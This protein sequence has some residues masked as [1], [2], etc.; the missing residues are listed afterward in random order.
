MLPLLR[1][2]LLR[3]GLLL[4]A[5]PIPKVSAWPGHDWAQWRQVTTWTRPNLVTRQTGQ[6]NL[7]PV[8]GTGDSRV[9]SP[10]LWDQERARVLA[11]VQ[12]IL[13]APA[14]LTPLPVEVREMETAEAEGYTRRHLLIRS[15]VEDW[16]P[17]YLLI[18]RQP[19]AARAPAMICL[20]QTVA[21]GKDEPCGLKGD[22][23]LA[24]AVELARRGYVCLAPDAIGFGERI[25]SGGQPYDGSL[26]FY[27][28]HPNWS[29][30]GKMVWDVSRLVDYLQTLPNVDARRIGSIGHSHGAYGT[31]F[32]AAL[33][34]RLT[35]A[36]A[37]CGFTTFRRDPNPERWSHLTALIP[38]VGDYLPDVASLPFDWQDVLALA[39]PRNLFVWYTTRDTIFPRTENLAALLTDVQGVYRLLGAERA[40]TWQSSDGAHQ[41]PKERREAAYRWLAEAWTARTPPTATKTASALF[42]GSLVERARTNAREHTWAAA[43][44]DP[45]VAA[46]QPWRERSDDELWELMF[47]NTLRRAWQVWSDGHCPACRKPVPMYEWVPEALT[48]PWKMRCP[49]C[50]ELF[51]KNDFAKF[52][53]S[54]LDAQN[55]FDPHRA[56]RS[57]LFNT[58]HPD[59]ADPLHRFGVDDGDGYVAEGKRWRFINAYLI[60]GQWKQAIVGGV[61]HLAAAYVATGDP[62]YAHKAGVLLDRIADLY[63]TFDFGKEGV[64]YEGAPRAG[65]VSTW[66]DACMEI[67]DLA[68]S[69]DAVFEEIARDP[70][71][72]T[73]LAGR[74]SRHALTNPKR[75]FADV[76]RNIDER[77]LR[78]TLEH[79]VK[80]E[81][82]YPT[83][84]KAML[85]LR[86]VL[87][88]PGNR[89]EVLSLMDEIIAKATAVDGL[90]G[91]KGIAGYSL[92]AP[93]EVAELLGRFARADPGFVRE[94]LRR[95]PQL[96]ET[97]RFHLD[98]W[99]LGL[100][101]PRTGDTGAFA[102]RDANYAGVAFSSNPGISPSGYA[103]LWDL[104]EATGDADYVRALYQANGSSTQGLPYDL[105]AAA[106]AEFQSRVATTLASTG[107]EIRLGSVNKTNW[108]LAILRA[109]TGSQARAVWLD[110]DSGERHGHADAMTLG[111]FAQGLDLLPDF[112]YPPVQYGGWA[113]PRAEW[114]TRSAAHNTVVI[115]GKDSKPGKG[116]TT[117]W[118]DG[119]AV[120][121]VSAAAPHLTGTQHYERTVA[122]VDISPETSYVLDIFHV[123]G[124]GEHTRFTHG[125]F[126]TLATQGIQA[127]PVEGSTLGGVMRG[128]RGDAHP[129]PGWSTTWNVEDRFRYLPADRQ[130]RLRQTDLTTDAEVQLAESWVAIGMFT[131]TADAWIPSV[132]VRRRALQ[133]PLISTFVEVLEPYASQS[134]LTSIRR[135]DLET[136]DGRKAPD[137]DVAVELTLADGHTDLLISRSRAG[138]TEAPSADRDRI[139]STRQIRVDG[140]L[141]WVRFGPDR[142]PERMALAQGTRLR[143]GGVL[144]RTKD[145]TVSLEID[146]T[147]PE[148]PQV[149]GPADALLELQKDG[150]PLWP[151][152]KDP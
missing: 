5:L 149:A 103:F 46:A 87:G 43:I 130:V 61:H 128:F 17:A 70:K 84:D 152:T 12:A 44:R 19:L 29:F 73:F 49:R 14:G 96:R 48:H 27:R 63:P 145:A 94:T 147:R 18:P 139:E 69:Y 92:I 98:T 52:Y 54:G 9:D 79:R 138:A 115:D 68:L 106:P 118:F 146:L 36:I 77:L 78:D 127:A 7:V 42:P 60:Y 148:A 114:Y 74:A 8:L 59:P 38:Q 75:T 55:V 11:T 23:E 26:R 143:A 137:R 41:F 28:R 116:Q 33:E 86:T 56:D 80:I 37:S 83:T 151:R 135:L 21:Q 88:W 67:Y 113:A 93:R 132:L 16:I 31:L 47:G 89:A 24:F 101:Y 124:G 65:Y 34:P 122:L 64:M 117:L 76:Q 123:A 39:A 35:A 121:A 133:P 97:Y 125:S 140:D 57:L 105:F 111:L 141:A 95:H 136:A 32:A 6:T 1:T 62:V 66:H 129:A 102:V 50:Q 72:V 2:A 25:A 104:Y 82:N 15:E 22:P 20:H 91:E 58:E 4:A 134:S 100:Y 99:C 126:G 3:L 71:L 85:I 108:C 81:S 51:P 40:L 150:K 131:G 107:T 142:H 119:Q 112:G 90:S 30:M 10:A 144:V 53:R 13:G 110:Y 120:R 45:L 109:G